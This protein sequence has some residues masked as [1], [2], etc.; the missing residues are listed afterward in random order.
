MAGRQVSAGRAAQARRE[1]RAETLGA[2][3]PALPGSDG[4]IYGYGGG[5][6]YLSGIEI[7]C[8]KPNPNFP[9]KYEEPH[10]EIRSPVDHSILASKIPC[11]GRA[12]DLNLSV[13]YLVLGYEGDMLCVSTGFLPGGVVIVQMP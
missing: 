7:Q 5:S 3:E 2:H 12:W 10:F 4:L 1:A 11:G 13:R 6:N 8:Q 9:W